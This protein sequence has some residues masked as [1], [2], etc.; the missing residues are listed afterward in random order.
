MGNQISELVKKAK[1]KLSE[2]ANR[3]KLDKSVINGFFIMGDQISR[4]EELVKK[5]EKKLNGWGIFGSKYHDA[6]D[7]LYKAVD[8]FKLAKSWD[9]VGAVY[10]KLASCH[11][12]LDQKHEASHSYDIV[13][14]YYKMTK[15]L[16][17]AISCLEKAAHILLDIGRLNATTGHY[18]EIAKLYEHEN[19]LEL[20]IVY[21]QKT[22]DLFQSMDLTSSANQYRQ[23]IAEYSAKV[24]KFQR[25]IVM[26]EEIAT[27]SIR[28]N[29]LK[30]GVRGHLLNA[31]ICQLCKGD[32][33]AISNAFERYQIVDTT[34]SGTR[35]CKLLMGLAAAIDKRDVA[36]FTSCLKEYDS[37][38]K[39]DEWRTPV[40]LK[41]K[42]ALKA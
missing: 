21:Y 20:A 14:D 27:Y 16:T 10:V 2:T 15:N 3:M 18:Q 24:G 13:A 11:L 38:I 17:E 30:Y 29:L 36:E 19:D 1:K 41:M 4:G 37:T 23:K 28:N 12:K 33:I 32:V 22:V 39:Q 26:F 5:A 35:E 40:L 8:R 34:F 7:L 42:E 6:A 25:S 31:G 9:R